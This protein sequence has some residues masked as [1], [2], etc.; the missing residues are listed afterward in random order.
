MV[1]K[2]QKTKFKKENYEILFL[3]HHSNF[4]TTRRMQG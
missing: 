3:L 2:I 1:G 4:R